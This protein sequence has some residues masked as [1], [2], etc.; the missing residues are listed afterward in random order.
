VVELAGYE[1]SAIGRHDGSQFVNQRG[2]ADTGSAADEYAATAPGG[3]LGERRAEVGDLDVA[4]DQPR[5]C[6]HPSWKV[7]LAW[8]DQR[9]TVAHPDQVVDQPIGS[10]VSVV[11]FLL[12]Q[13]HDDCRQVGR[14]RWVDDVG[15][16]GYKSQ[17]IMNEPDRVARPERRLTRGEFVQG[18]SQRVQIRPLVHRPPHPPGL[19]RRQIR[20]RPNDLGVVG[21]LR[22][23]LRGGR[24]Q[25]EVDHHGVPILFGEHDVARVDVPM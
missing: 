5:R 2:L 1:P 19:L 8:P 21:E 11:R 22:P 25:R 12:Q 3:N 20:Q 16:R 17:L 6:Q 24:G 4:A 23:Q 9:L 14:H 7:M 10:L 13:M 18:R 15:C